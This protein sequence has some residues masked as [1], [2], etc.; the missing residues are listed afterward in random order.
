MS[1]ISDDEDLAILN[2]IPMYA[3][4]YKI[5]ST[6]INVVAAPVPFAPRHRN[7]IASQQVYYETRNLKFVSYYPS[8][9][10]LSYRGNKKYTFCAHFPVTDKQRDGERSDMSD[11]KII[12]RTIEAYPRDA[13]SRAAAARR[14]RHVDEKGS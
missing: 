13:P 5:D 4:Q 10:L 9:L 12:A 6:L 11:R 7:S 2:V 3:I 1:D 14:E 8:T